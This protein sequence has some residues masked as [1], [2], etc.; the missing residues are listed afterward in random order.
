MTSDLGSIMRQTLGSGGRSMPGTSLVE[1]PAAE[2]RSPD[3]DAAGQAAASFGNLLDTVRRAAATDRNAAPVAPTTPTDGGSTLTA[4]A[5]TV[6]ITALAPLISDT[7]A[8][9]GALAHLAMGAARRPSAG[10][11]GPAEPPAKAEAAPART[12]L[13]ALAQSMLLA[14]LAPPSAAAASL[15]T[16]AAST[17]QTPNVARPA[18]V[19]PSAMTASAT[20]STAAGSTGPADP[21]PGPTAPP[22]NPATPVTG[23]PSMSARPDLPG[24]SA[25]A[26]AGTAGTGA[27]LPASGPTD[28]T[29]TPALPGPVL[30]GPAQ[31]GTSPAP[32]ITAAGSAAAPA[33]VATGSGPAG[34]GTPNPAS[35]NSGDVALS[36]VPALVATG[37]PSATAPSSSRRL[38]TGA[39]QPASSPA[40]ADRPASA[41]ASPGIATGAATSNGSERRDGSAGSA[42]GHGRPGPGSVSGAATA[43]SQL[44]SV[45]QQA[46]PSQQVAAAVSA[47]VTLQTPTGQDG[48]ADNARS[49]AA[50]ASATADASATGQM[51]A[52]ADGGREIVIRLDPEH[53]GS[54]SIRLKMSGGKIDLAIT[55]AETG[56]LDVLNRDRHLLTAAVSAAGLGG[57]S[58]ILKAGAPEAP[59]AQAFTTG[60]ADTGSRQ[61]SDRGASASGDPADTGGRRR[62][63][64]PSRP[65]SNDGAAD[66]GAAAVAPARA[67]GLYV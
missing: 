65:S 38:A 11:D 36:V 55:V 51:R 12:D 9:M 64:H 20:V 5:T 16:A 13:G 21:Q 46:T 4:S 57:D 35:D 37:G 60:G 22:A 2:S 47:L 67:G 54:V 26:G 62:D 53:L 32:Q 19:P 28:P 56:T 3:K 30:A 31:A 58:L 43:A 44:A 41:P 42:H 49:A 48:P 45:S 39:A 25:E 7:A 6:S 24:R 66:D 27:S 10:T 40:Q 52:T 1:G 18:S 33:P 63:D 50:P 23:A 59:A 61:T 8:T 29:V 14:G 34:D 15:P 17:S